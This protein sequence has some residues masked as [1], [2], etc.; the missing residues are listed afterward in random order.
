MSADSTLILVLGYGT[1]EELLRLLGRIPVDRLPQTL[2]A[3]VIVDSSVDATSDASLVSR[4]VDR[5]KVTVLRTAVSPGYGGSQKLGYRYGI[6][7]GFD[8][9]ALLHC[10]GRYPPELLPRLLRPLRLGKSDAVLGSRVL[11]SADTPRTGVPSYKLLGHRILTR[12]Q[13]WILGSSLSDIHSGYRA[14]S[15]R[16][17]SSVPFEYNTDG[18]EFDTEVVVQLLSRMFRI[19]DIPIPP[20]QAK[21]PSVFGGFAYAYNALRTTLLSR[22]QRLGVFYRRK[23]ARQTDESPYTLKLGFCSSHS[24]ALQAISPGERILDLG[25]GAGHLAEKLRSL[26]G[27]KV[28][29]VDVVDQSA[30]PLRQRM[31]R[32]IEHNLSDGTLPEEIQ[33]SPDFDTILLLD[34]IEHLDAPE[35]LL[36]SLRHSFGRYSC[37]YI[38]TVPNIAF[39]LTRLGLLFGTFHYGPRGILDLTH[40]RLFTLSSIRNIV[41]ESGLTIERLRGVPAPYPLALGD[42]VLARALLR[43][44]R[45]L[46]RLSAGLFSYQLYLEGRFVPSIESLLR[47]NIH[48]VDSVA[49]LAGE[50]TYSNPMGTVS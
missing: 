11:E 9:V 20:Y 29:G 26:K 27:C 42:S 33:H 28:T 5:L 30:T 13:N 16:A 32:Y 37:R 18:R 17:L 12:L 10:D 2:E 24:L 36:T 25:C 40:K 8:H 46:I 48:D 7:S 43:I 31:D 49:S 45:F 21:E 39:F 41:E 3:L 1:E 4:H 22:L 6:A 15:L 23:Y 34:I 50:R 47:Y 38:L 14:Y 19:R 44:N 35:K